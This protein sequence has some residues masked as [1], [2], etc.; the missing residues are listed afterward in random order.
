M[1]AVEVA[2]AQGLRAIAEAM[3]RAKPEEMVVL[4]D[5]MATLARELE[6]RR[7]AARA[8]LLDLEA[9]RKRGRR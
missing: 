2:L 6:S 3:A 4:A 9:A 1:D 8:N 5:R 7:L